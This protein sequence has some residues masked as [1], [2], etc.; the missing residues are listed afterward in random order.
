M[1]KTVPDFVYDAALDRVAD[2]H[3]QLVLCE[4]QPSSYASATTNK[5]SGGK[6][7]A[8]RNLTLGDGNGDYTIA[9]GDTSGRKLTIAA[10]T[11]VTVAVAGA[12]N[13]LAVVNTSGSELGPVT[14]ATTASV[15]TSLLVNLGSFDLMEILDP[16]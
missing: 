7:L 8:S 15:T 10:Q 4:G 14:T 13:H 6:K 3:N 11:S 12:Y 5:G 2:Q 9:N 16:S 1:A